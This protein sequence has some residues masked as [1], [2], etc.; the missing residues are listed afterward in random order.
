MCDNQGLRVTFIPASFIC[1]HSAA[2]SS[3]ASVE[4]SIVQ[5][6]AVSIGHCTLHIA[7]CTFQTELH[8]YSVLS[9][10][11]ECEDIPS[12][13]GTG[14]HPLL[15]E[16][17]SLCTSW[18]QPQQKLAATMMTYLGPSYHHVQVQQA[19][20]HLVDKRHGTCY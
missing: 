10:Y 7:H 9:T 17:I 13:I 8:C 20:R 1:L 14:S 16:I 15:G 6:I 18:T 2:G 5:S 19:G 12:G 4:Q 3:A 11:M